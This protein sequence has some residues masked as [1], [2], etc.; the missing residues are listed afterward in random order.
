MKICENV[1][2]MSSRSRADKVVSF[3]RKRQQSSEDFNF[4]SVLGNEVKIL[5][6]EKNPRLWTKKLEISNP[7]CIKD[8]TNIIGIQGYIPRDKVV[9]LLPKKITH[10]SPTSSPK[11]SLKVSPK[12]SSPKSPR[13]KATTLPRS[14]ATTLPI[15]IEDD[16]NIIGIQGYIP[17][18]KVVNLQPRKI[19]DVSPMDSSPKTSLKVTAGQKI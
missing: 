17:R 11:T 16:T 12:N 10:L 8:D 14:R 7:T 6:N 5:E 1:R 2:P 4:S 15:N 18:D 13:P 3:F 19:L 9:E